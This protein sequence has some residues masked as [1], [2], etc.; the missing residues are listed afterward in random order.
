MM[1]NVIIMI[2]IMIM[3]T[4][5]IRSITITTDSVPDFRGMMITLIMFTTIMMSMSNK[6][7]HY[8]DKIFKLRKR[9]HRQI[10]ECNF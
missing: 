5:T 2:T 6:S 8:C 10:Y 7:H 4:T 9:R 3:I 1:F